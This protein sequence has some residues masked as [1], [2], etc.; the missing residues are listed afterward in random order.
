MA[1]EITTEEKTFTVTHADGTVSTV[2]GTVTTTHHGETDEDGNPKISVHIGATPLTEP[3]P[4]PVH[5]IEGDIITEK[6]N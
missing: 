1:E 2:Q 6:E 4:A 5:L 3:A